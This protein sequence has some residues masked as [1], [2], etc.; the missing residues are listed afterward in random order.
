[1]SVQIHWPFFIGLLN[2]TMEFY[3]FLIFFDIQSLSNK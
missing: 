2:F 3:E 1:M